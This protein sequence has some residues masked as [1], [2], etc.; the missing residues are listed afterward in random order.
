MNPCQTGDIGAYG[1]NGIGIYTVRMPV[2]WQRTL[3]GY[4]DRRAQVLPVDA[5]PLGD[6]RYR[7]RLDFRID[8]AH[9]LRLRGALP[10]WEPRPEAKS[11]IRF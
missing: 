10:R 7:R 8:R 11:R 1:R 9:F 3:V 5:G 4:D 6:I 2:C